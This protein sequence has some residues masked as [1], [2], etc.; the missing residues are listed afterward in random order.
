MKSRT[1]LPVLAILLAF[2][3]ASA[4]QVTLD[5]S[6]IDGSLCVGMDCINGEDFGFRTV[7]LKENN[8]RLY[9]QDT[10]STSAFPTRDWQLTANDSANGGLN[11]FAL[12]DIDSGRTPFS[13][14]A[15]APEAGLVLNASGNLG[16][17]TQDAQAKIHAVNDNTPTLRLDQT[18]DGGYQP[19]VWDLL[20]NEENLAIR[21]ATAGTLPFTIK[22]G[23]DSN[24]L[25]IENGGNVTVA[26][27]LTTGSSRDIK[28]VWPIAEPDVLEKLKK[29]EVARWQYKNDAGG[30]THLGP[31]A[32]DFHSAFGLGADNK[33]IA[34]SD[35]AGV[36]MASVQ[37]L[38]TKVEEQDKE[39]AELKAVNKSLEE[40]MARIEQQL[41][42]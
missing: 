37:A 4:D 19:Q 16:L 32:E 14:M 41:S 38:L 8:V 15:D 5:D 40:R 7:V 9:F 31:M 34:P 1:A 25:V 26:G 22:P 33:H 10:S 17:G 21:D 6:I 27:M 35:I 3:P 23:S 20:G 29:L 36:T 11:R 39:M 2:T 42:P 30:G 12:D 28:N 18:G 13:I 24:T